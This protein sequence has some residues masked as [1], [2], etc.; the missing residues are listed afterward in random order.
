M[1]MLLGQYSTGK[2]T[3]IKNLLKMPYPG[4]TGAGVDMEAQEP[5]CAE[6]KS[7]RCGPGLRVEPLGPMACVGGPARG[8]AAHGDIA[9]CAVAALQFRP[10]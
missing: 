7:H 4:E 5:V 10:S 8:L 9:F 3:F 1:V 2:T 6:G